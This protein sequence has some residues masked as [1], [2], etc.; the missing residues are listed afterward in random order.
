MKKE[1][2][3]RIKK[4]FWVALAALIVAV[5]IFFFLSSEMMQKN[6]L[7]G[8]WHSDGN[9]LTI[10]FKSDGSFL[11]DGLSAYEGTQ[12]EPKLIYEW[13]K[14]DKTVEISLTDESAEEL[15]EAAGSFVSIEDVMNSLGEADSRFDYSVDGST[16]TLTGREYG[17]KTEYE[18][19]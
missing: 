10:E 2:S 18:R 16:L 14:E 11:I 15:R 12:V 13:D 17:A 4:S 6:P 1:Q 5:I 7:V 3:G 19:R 8:T 9:D